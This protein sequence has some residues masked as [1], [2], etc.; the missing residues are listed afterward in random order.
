MEIFQ[1]NDVF[2]TKSIADFAFGLDW[3]Q[4][5]CSL[6]N[7]LKFLIGRCQI[8][9]KLNAFPFGVMNYQLYLLVSFVFFYFKS[10]HQLYEHTNDV[11][12]NRGIKQDIV[13]T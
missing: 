3:Y 10:K 9:A 6:T 4:G 1:L 5:N 13:Y 7:D 11:Q 2:Q 8:P 12:T